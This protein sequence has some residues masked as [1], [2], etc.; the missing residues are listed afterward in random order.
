[1]KEDEAVHKIGHRCAGEA[2]KQ[3]FMRVERA[4]ELPL[5]HFGAPRISTTSLKA[6]ASADRDSGAFLK[7]GISAP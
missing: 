5:Q 2:P 4:S 6:G 1:V 7:P 3:Q